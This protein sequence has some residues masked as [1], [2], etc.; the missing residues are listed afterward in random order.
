MSTYWCDP[1][2]PSSSMS[3]SSGHLSSNNGCI[4]DDDTKIGT[5]PESGSMSSTASRLVSPAVP[6]FSSSTDS[7]GQV[8]SKNDILCEIDPIIE[9]ADGADHHN[10]DGEPMKEDD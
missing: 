1:S 8:D 2:N 10:L 3:G 7:I 4:P 6:V 9:Q 5:A